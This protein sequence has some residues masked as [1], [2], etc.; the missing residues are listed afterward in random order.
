[1]RKYTIYVIVSFYMRLK[2][3]KIHIASPIIML[4]LFFGV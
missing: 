1:M 4:L 3:E 2:F